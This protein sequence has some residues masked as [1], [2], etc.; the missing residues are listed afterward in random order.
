MRL[1]DPMMDLVPARPWTES[2]PDASAASLRGV[3]AGVLLWTLS[4]LLPV[5]LAAQEIDLDEDLR[6]AAQFG[7]LERVRR[8]IEEGA[9]V[10]AGRGPDGE[11]PLMAASQTGNLE[12]VRLLIENG[13]ELHARDDYGNLPLHYAFVGGEEVALLLLEHT[14]GVDE[15]DDEAPVAPLSLAVQYDF[16]EVARLLLERG[17]DV[18]LPDARGETPLMVA[19]AAGSELAVRLLYCHGASVTT[20]DTEG[21]TALSLGKAAGRERVSRFLESPSCDRG[22]VESLVRAKRLLREADAVGG[23]LAETDALYGEALGLRESVLG[24]AHPD[25]TWIRARLDERVRFAAQDGDLWRVKQLIGMGASINDRGSM[26]MTALMSAAQSGN[27]ELVRFLIDR[28]ADPSARDSL[29]EWT[30]LQHAFVGGNEEVV[31]LLLTHTRDVNSAGEDGSTAL[32][33]SAFGWPGL[34]NPA[35]RREFVE[36]TYLLL[37]RGSDPEA[38]AQ[39]ELWTPL[40]IAAYREHEATVRLLY[41]YGASPATEDRDGQTA[42]DIARE[43]GFTHLT[44]FL[45][46]PTCDRGGID[47]LVKAGSIERRARALGAHGLHTDAIPLFTQVLELRKEA[48]GP[49]NPAVAIT[50]GRLAEQ[51]LRAG[52]LVAAR[53]L[54]ERS[55]A[56]LEDARAAAHPDVAANL[57]NLAMVL[58]E[59][60]DFEAAR[61]M[62]ERALSV[63]EQAHGPYHEEVAAQLDNLGRLL[64]RQG[65]AV[66]ADSLYE[67]ALEIRAFAFEETAREFK[68]TA[69]NNFAFLKTVL[70]DFSAADTLYREA[71]SIFRE[72]RGDEHPNVARVLNQLGELH[73]LQEQAEAARPYLEESLAISERSLGADHVQ[74]AVALTYLAVVA[75]AEGDSA[76]ARKQLLR[77]AEIVDKHIEGV[78]P[79][80][81]AAEQRAFLRQQVPAQTALLLLAFRDDARLSDA[82][83]WLLRWKGLLAHHLRRQTVIA[84]SARGPEAERAAE[85]HH[86]RSELAAWYQRAAEVPAADWKA[87]SDELTKRKERLEREL[88]RAASESAEALFDPLELSGLR[89]RLPAAAGFVDVYRYGVFLPARYGVIYSTRETPPIFIDLGPAAAVDSLIVVWR[90]KVVEGRDAVA[91]WK[92]LSAVWSP[93]AKALGPDVERLWVSPDGMLARIPWSLLAEGDRRTE[94]LWLSQVDSG[95][96]LAALLST[97]PPLESNEERIALLV[98]DV[99]FNAGAGILESAWKALPGTAAEIESLVAI[100]R[101]ASVAA[102]VLAGSEAT[103]EA[104]ADRMPGAEVV[105]LATHGFFYAESSEAYESRGGTAT[106]G[107]AAAQNTGTA[108]NPLVESGIALAGAN[109]RDSITLAPRGLL[110]AEELLGLEL[111]MTDLVVLSACE[112]GRGEE[113]TGQGVMGLRASV[114]A[115]GARSMLMSLWKVPD[116]STALLME[117]FYRGL[118]LRGLTKAEALRQA[119]AEVREHPSGEYRAPLHWAAWVLAGEA[120]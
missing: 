24:A 5:S 82:Y 66:A 45:G 110:T 20:T 23:S 75:L 98:G 42:L 85:L 65:R 54:L 105:H 12:L 83:S 32:H 26:G 63:L 118:W 48:L 25:V 35:P 108:R 115:A 14:R 50:L 71:L 19:A 55:L 95:R 2:L 99:D 114:M 33:L 51:H 102:T 56:I 22:A 78:L 68:A 15:K 57:G 109:V 67:R 119:Q 7:D 76:V 30:S 111:P 87:R 13:A 59:Q 112:T 117:E 38:R 84:R 46:S 29:Y 81:S 70:G 53:T 9:S 79:T 97:E 11:T 116:E 18:E 73:L 36:A 106:D 6:V 77:A 113:I 40:M 16:V 34:D 44:R 69:L 91:E 43:N 41:C 74:V 28:G 17:A 93:L 89:S 101:D 107:A 52:E 27:L 8:L 103:K 88:A 60:G 104:V 100:A 1:S 10:N 90:R 96:E 58:E 39:A 120:W 21:H 37:E 49:T 47:D 61:P 4:A 80:L 3:L 86:L 72:V 64:V 62:V 94:N 31:I 92:Q